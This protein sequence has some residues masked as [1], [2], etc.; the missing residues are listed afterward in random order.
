M[1]PTETAV[2]RI[3]ELLK[4]ENRT[5]L[6]EWDMNFLVSCRNSARNFTLS[7]KQKQKIYNI[8]KKIKP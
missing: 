8:Y 3:D 1:T 7:A 2:L 6:A 4:Q 5:K